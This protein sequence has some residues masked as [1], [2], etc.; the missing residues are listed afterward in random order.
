MCFFFVLSDNNFS[1]GARPDTC[2][3]SGTSLSLD[4]AVKQRREFILDVI[5][6]LDAVWGHY[7]NV[8]VPGFKNPPTYYSFPSLNISKTPPQ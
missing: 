6:F 8:W 1:E 4:G 5:L 2:F 3:E 7:G